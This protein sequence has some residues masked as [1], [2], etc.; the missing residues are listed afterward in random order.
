M[1]FIK[2]NVGSGEGK[3]ESHFRLTFVDSCES[4]VPDSQ[5]GPFWTVVTTPLSIWGN[6]FNAAL[7]I[8]VVDE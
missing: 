8:I 4:E 1:F 5:Q 2:S 7:L 3:N 6:V